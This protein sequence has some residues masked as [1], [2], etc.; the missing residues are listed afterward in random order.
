M[1]DI[2][3]HIAS[4]VAPDAIHP[5]SLLCSMVMKR[6]N[7]CVISGP[8]KGMKYVNTSI[9]SSLFPKRYFLELMSEH[10]STKMRWFYLEPKPDSRKKP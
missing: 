9:G 10:R 7:S 8:F 2:I 4:R 3:R 1:N 5:Y 6:A